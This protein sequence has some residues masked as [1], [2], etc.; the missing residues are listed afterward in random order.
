MVRD[1]D[2]AEELAQ[3][4]LVIALAE[5]PESGVPKN[6]GAWLMAAA[7]R[8][9][10]D[11]FRRREMQA[12][13]HA[14]IGRDLEAEQGV[15]DIEAAM[16]DDIGDELLSLIF[17]A[18]H[19]VLSAE[20]HVALTLRLIGGLTTEE[21]AR[22]FLTSETTIAQ[23]IVRAKKAISKAGVAYEVPRGAELRARLETVL[24]VIYLIFNEGYAAT[25]GPDL[26]RPALCLE[27]Q[28]LG[29]ILAGLMPQEADVF[30][31]LALMEIQSSR[32][33]A[34]VGQDGLPVPLDRQNRA[35]WD[36]LAIR[37]GLTALDRAHSLGGQSR[38]YVLQADLAACH[39][40]ALRAEDTDWKRIAKLYD[41]LSEI[42]PSPVVA[43]NRA[44]AYA[45]A[46]GPAAGLE[47]VEGIE[48]SGALKGY[49]LLPATK[50]DFLFRAG[51]LAEAKAKFKEAAA[52]SGNDKEKAFLLKRA[53]ECEPSVR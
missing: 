7:K 10:I 38:A 30:G 11:G 8:R 53:E 50:G 23:R 18:C 36:R 41:R 16:D 17:T 31:L 33:A 26:L 3:D 2:L 14:E 44:V 15:E 42:M 34:R 20:A 40:R 24:S 13:K 52:L 43:L 5:W 51:R 27:A 6:P 37:R 48:N 9:A 25:S 28:R 45:M 19:P 47:I 35:R 32:F 4:A 22:A 29:R 12:R 21:I 49:A 46:Y 39:A 1:I